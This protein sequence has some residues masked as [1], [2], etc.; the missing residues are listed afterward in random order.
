MF[1]WPVCPC[2]DHPAVWGNVR[3]NAVER[4]A[5]WYVAQDA[6]AGPAVATT[7]AVE[8]EA[9]RTAHGESH[10]QAPSSWT[11]R[12]ASWLAGFAG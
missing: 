11:A 6:R 9:A 1:F 7:E 3:A 2:T 12:L 10:T 8:M 5:A 4:V